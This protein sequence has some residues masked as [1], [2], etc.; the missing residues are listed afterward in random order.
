MTILEGLDTQKLSQ[1]VERIGAI[2]QWSGFNKIL[3]EWN[4]TWI[5]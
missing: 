4:K 3:I 2:V 1:S 5:D